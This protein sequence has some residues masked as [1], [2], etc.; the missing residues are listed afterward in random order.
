MNK[1]EVANLIK[2][3]VDGSCG[4]W[5]WDDFTSIRQTDPKI[6]QVRLHILTIPDKY[7]SNNPKHWSNED[8]VRVLQEIAESLLKS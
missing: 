3:F 1:V 5:D 6:E 2:S 4:K 7:P 8:G